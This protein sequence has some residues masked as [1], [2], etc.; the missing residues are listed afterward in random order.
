MS[1]LASR[2]TQTISSAWSDAKEPGASWM[3][4]AASHLNFYRVHFV[5]FVL[6]PLM[7]SLIMY[8]SNGPN[9]IRYI[10]CLFNCVSATC[11]CGLNSSLLG[12]MTGW[13]QV[14]L[15]IQM[16]EGSIVTVSIVTIMI[17]RHFF[18]KA[19][20]E[21]IKLDEKSCRRVEDVEQ[22]QKRRQGTFLHRVLHP[23]HHPSPEEPIMMDKPLRAS[24][25]SSL[26][27]PGD[28]ETLEKSPSTDRA[29]AK[30]THDDIVEKLRLREQERM[31]QAQ[32]DK[33]RREQEKRKKKKTGPVTVGMIKRTD[34]PPK[35]NMMSV[36]GWLSDHPTAEGPAG[37]IQDAQALARETS[38]TGNGHV[39]SQPVTADNSANISRAAS[40]ALNSAD[41]GSRDRS[42]QA[43]PFDPSSPSSGANKQ[44]R[45]N[46]DP[47]TASRTPNLEVPRTNTIAHFAESPHPPHHTLN[48]AEPS[49]EAYG[50]RQ[51]VYEPEQTI[52]QRHPTAASHNLNLERT[53]TRRSLARHETM[54]RS[55]TRQATMTQGF[56]G[57]P[58]PL[59]EGVRVLRRAADQAIRKTMTMPQTY[60]R[61]GTVQSAHSTGAIS[62]A[63][64]N[65]NYLSFDPQVRRNSHFVKLTAAQEEELGGVEYRALSVLLKI[66]IGYYLGVHLIACL[67]LAPYL[68][69]GA[70][71]YASNFTQTGGYTS[72]VWYIFF[73]VWS[74]FSNTG[75]SLLDSSLTLFQDAYL[76]LIVTIFLILAGNT[77]FPVFLRLTI[78]ILAKCS[79]RQSRYRETLDFILDHPRRCYIYLFP[80]YQTIYLAVVVLLLTCIDWLSFLVLDIGN[81]YLGAIPLHTRV[82]DG[83]LQ[84]AA[85]RAAGFQVVNLAATAP[86]VQL[87]YV[88]MM[89][90][91]VYPIALS[92][93]ATNVYED[94]ALGIYDD[95]DDESEVDAEFEQKKD[96]KGYLAYHARRQLAFDLWYVVL[97]AWLI[98]IIEK[99]NIQNVDLPWFSIFSIIFEIVSA[100]GTVGLSL[101]SPVLGTSLSGSF[102]QLSK[103]II[104]MVIIRGRHRG[105]PIAIDRSIM[106]PNALDM[107]AKSDAEGAS[108]HRTKSWRR[109][110]LVPELTSDSRTRQDSMPGE[111]VYPPTFS[112]QGGIVEDEKTQ[113]QRQ[114]S[115]PA[116][117]ISFANPHAARD[118]RTLQNGKDQSSSESSG[119][120]LSVEE[121]ASL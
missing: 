97:A 75:M 106:L 100:Y 12:V 16:I 37:E 27:P 2:A 79:P 107:Q 77:A 78:W 3:E 108:L 54:P 41:F 10:D 109:A 45:R 85:V 52:R 24:P 1:K 118:A 32:A 98:C 8:A 53:M 51:S 9:H 6:N 93:R 119:S 86:A 17:R 64:T 95:D 94:K 47:A 14:I 101:G 112:D 58:N 50:R 121:K 113:R 29:R 42:G 13:Q 28:S 81:D 68:T 59:A 48:F 31:Q 34:E 4:A 114:Q 89:Y 111:H 56:G 22:A 65:R 91:A 102:S 80:T 73:N 62:A 92:I 71:Q 120:G 83:L 23:G 5:F 104:C 15:F 35:V 60:S 115:V 18:R 82:I 25:S 46:S 63:T 40:P 88:I 55:V 26:S 44:R 76:L 43:S 103:I 61:T 72:P 105:L 90:V 69:Y 36:G 70:P 117:G 96:T 30:K 11:V 21:L 67:I 33:E 87:L 39:P 57:F 38:Q 49:Q 66:V 74:A 99:H 84:S 110:S 7:W 20:K 19:F 116:T